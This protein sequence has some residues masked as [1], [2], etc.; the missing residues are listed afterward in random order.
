MM[1]EQLVL[2]EIVPNRKPEPWMFPLRNR[3]IS[4]LSD[5]VLII[6]A[7]GRSGSL[8]TAHSALEQGR[9]VFAVP[10]PINSPLS[11]GTNLLIQDGAK[12]VLSSH[13]IEEELFPLT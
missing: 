1:K 8:I 2:S 13:D 10:G 3:I 4:G 5:G 12:L 7:K 6:E 11:E 9:G